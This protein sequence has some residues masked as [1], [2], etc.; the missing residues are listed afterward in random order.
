[1]PLLLIYIYVVLIQR[2]DYKS[3][4]TDFGKNSSYKRQFPEIYNLKK[5]TLPS[6][7]YDSDG[8]QRSHYSKEL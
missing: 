1:M 2:H 3:Q 4:Y 6:P 8:N 7:H 5:R